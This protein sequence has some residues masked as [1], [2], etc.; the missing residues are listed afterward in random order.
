MNSRIYLFC[1]FL[2]FIQGASYAQNISRAIFKISDQKDDIPFIELTIEEVIFILNG[3]GDLM[4][5]DVL[6][7]G[8]YDYFFN[9]LIG[10]RD[11]LIKTIGD[12]QVDYFT[13][14]FVGGRTGLLKSV[15]NLKIDYW[16]N[17]FIGK[18]EGKL[19]S[20]GN[21]KIDYW[22]N[23]FIGKRDGKIKSIGDIKIDYYTNDF[24]GNRDGKVKSIGN[25][26]VT[27]W[28][29]D[30]HGRDGLIKS[31]EGNS[32]EVFVIRQ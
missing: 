2:L 27:Y 1:F 20:I 6:E 9:D 24:I 19:K 18:R 25:V 3:Q 11:G 32:R 31:I 5:F 12:I 30:F 14:D 7:G 13:N 4:Y 21:I 23:D 8:E 26:T 29:N 17:D 16:T 22:T 10:N 15:G 28:T